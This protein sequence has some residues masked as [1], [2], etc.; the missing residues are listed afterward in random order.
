MK[1]E[2]VR[3]GR[4]ESDKQV[5]SAAML[6]GAE[7]DLKSIREAKYIIIS[8]DYKDTTVYRLYEQHL[9]RK[10]F[11]KRFKTVEAAIKFANK[12]EEEK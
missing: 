12:Y 3:N 10:E 11:L 9:G 6:V 2:Q 8:G 1:F 5:C 7:R 4:W